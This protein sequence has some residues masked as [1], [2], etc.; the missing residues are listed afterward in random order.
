MRVRKVRVR[1]GSCELKDLN[2]KHCEI[3]VS[4]SDKGRNY[5]QAELNVTE[6]KVIELHA[7]SWNCMQAHVNEY[8][9]M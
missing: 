5:M 2:N 7:S 9:L 8:K 4:C 6:C 1:S 3:L